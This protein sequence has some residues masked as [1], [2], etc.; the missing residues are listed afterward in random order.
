MRILLH[1]C[2]A[3]CSIMFIK[4]IKKINLDLTLF[5]YN[6]N[7]YPSEEYCAR[8]SSFEKFVSDMGLNVQYDKDNL[9]KDI[10]DNFQTFINSINIKNRCE[11]CYTLRIKKTSITAKEEHFTY[12]STT[13]L[14]S[15]Y[16]KHDLICEVSRKLSDKY[17]IKFFYKDFRP[18]FRQGQAEAR[19]L[20]LY[21]Q[22]YCGCCFS[23]K[24]DR[25]PS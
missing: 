22:N 18:S 25:L 24:L 15:P 19:K 20:G 13:L 11:G 17:K 8:K 1:V 9:R 23:R 14:V 7:I 5:W 21:I 6:P 10:D 4:E 2:C 12:F 3:P 16:Q